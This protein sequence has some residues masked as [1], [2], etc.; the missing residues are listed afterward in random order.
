MA[1]R[2]TKLLILDS[3]AFSV[4]T[5]GAAIDLE[6]YLAFCQSL[7]D[8]SYYVNLD[9]IPGKP[10]DKKTLTKETVAESCKQG[11]RNYRRMIEVLPKEKVIPVFHQGDPIAWLEKYLSFGVPYIG[12]SPANDRAT[13]AKNRPSTVT[14]AN[15]AEPLSTKIQWLRTLRPYLF[16]GAGHPVVRT[17][18]FAVTS[19]ELMKFWEWHSVDSAS[20]KL[21]GAWGNVYVP[22]V[23]GD[24][25]FLFTEPPNSVRMS[26]TASSESLGKLL[27]RVNRQ[28]YEK[29]QPDLMRFL[30]ECD[31][32][33]GAFEVKP[34]EEGYK[35]KR[36]ADE[37]WFS[38]KDRKVLVPTEKGVLTSVEERLR[39][40]AHCIQMANNALKQTVHHIYFAGAVMPYPLE[41]QL[42]RRL[43]SYFHTK[44]ESGSKVLNNHTS[45]IRERNSNA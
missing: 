13:G 7:P 27:T 28:N 18:G 26:G 3:G 29:L 34:V 15:R 45:M 6:A 21:A 33:L 11:W 1:N 17:H 31:V 24:G 38:K 32:S 5:Q 41:F 10:G 2:P 9:V 44:G 22:Q 19:Y 43:L 37:I 20:W 16:D 12:I 14:F 23:R 25:S 8:V 39:V 36:D 42:G 40:N 4:W 30:A 35:L